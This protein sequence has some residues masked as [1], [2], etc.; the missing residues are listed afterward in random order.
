LKAIHFIHYVNEDYI[1]V[2]LKDRI[3]NLKYN[4]KAYGCP[5][6]ANDLCVE[7]E[8]VLLLYS[9]EELKK[10]KAAQQGA[11]NNKPVEQKSINWE[12]GNLLGQGGMKQFNIYQQNRLWSSVLGIKQ[13]YWRTDGS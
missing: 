3:L 4:F 11:I 6:K 1:H 13:G 7:L 9:K 12:K 5:W 2:T 8:K 10:L